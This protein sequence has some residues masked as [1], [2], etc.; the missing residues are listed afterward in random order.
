MCSDTRQCKRGLRDFSADTLYEIDGEGNCDEFVAE[1]ELVTVENGE[2]V[3]EDENGKDEETVKEEEG[4]EGEITD[5]C[6]KS[7]ESDHD[8]DSE[9]ERERQLMKAM[10]LPDSFTANE[11][12]AKTKKVHLLIC[13]TI[14]LCLN[15]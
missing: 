8:V 1:P 9:T 2:N 13:F 7:V 6:E 15:V 5:I 4:D 10:G 3:K 14:M 11:R 12:A